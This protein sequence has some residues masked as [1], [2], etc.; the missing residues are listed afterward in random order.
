MP[1]LTIG[2]TIP[3]IEADSTHGRI[4]LYD[5]IG[6]GWVIIFSHPGMN[7]YSLILFPDEVD[8]EGARLWYLLFEIN[9]QAILLRYVLRSSGRWRLIL[10]SLPKEE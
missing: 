1:G 8:G 7:F 5:F 9:R 2:D 4:K 6:D 10:K 3:N